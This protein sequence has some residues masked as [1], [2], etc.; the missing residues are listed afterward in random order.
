MNSSL[1]IYIWTSGYRYVTIAKN[2]ISIH[3]IIQGKHEKC[4]CNIKLFQGII[5]FPGFAATTVFFVPWENI[6]L[7]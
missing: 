6:S 3:N 2:I 5:D 1:V 7:I 4:Y